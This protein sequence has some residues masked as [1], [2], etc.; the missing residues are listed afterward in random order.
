[1]VFHNQNETKQR[2]ENMEAKLVCHDMNFSGMENDMMSPCTSTT[3]FG[4]EISLGYALC[5][6]GGWRYSARPISG[7]TRLA[8]YSH[9][10]YCNLRGRQHLQR[11]LPQ[12]QSLLQLLEDLPRTLEEEVRQTVKNLCNTSGCARRPLEAPSLLTSIID[13]KS[14]NNQNLRAYINQVRSLDQ[15]ARTIRGRVMWANSAANERDKGLSASTGR[16]GVTAMQRL[17]RSPRDQGAPG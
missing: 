16:R 17:Q 14:P 6:H 8:T 1:M 12:I 13:A 11:L 9:P 3:K 7:L 5:W 4:R 15:V 10:L 2:V